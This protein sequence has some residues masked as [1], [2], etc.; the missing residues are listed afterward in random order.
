MST[1]TA[2]SK[3]DMLGLVAAT[4]V[5]SDDSQVAAAA[6]AI[7]GLSEAV[8][9]AKKT[10]AK[11]STGA[12]VKLAKANAEKVITP[13]NKGPRGFRVD[14]PAWLK[15]IM[16]RKGIALSPSNLPKLLDTAEVKGLTITPDLEQSEIVDMLAKAMDNRDADGAD[17]RHATA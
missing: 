7:P 15:S 1:K 14:S 5:A 4:I 3:K 2:K 16:E 10:R 11:P 12:A 17:R 9:T 8:N 13:R 6:Q